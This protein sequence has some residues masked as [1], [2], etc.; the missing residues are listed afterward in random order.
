LFSGGRKFNQCL[1]D[2]SDVIS[3]I[4]L[5]VLWPSV[6]S[7]IVFLCAFAP[8]RETFFVFLTPVY[9][10]QSTKNPAVPGSLF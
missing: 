3:F 5:L 4:D 7:I 2:S 8:L 6:A 1:W 9:F 10:L